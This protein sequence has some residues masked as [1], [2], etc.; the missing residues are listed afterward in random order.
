M[1]RIPVRQF[2]K[3]EQRALKKYIAFGNRVF[4]QAL[5]IQADNY[6]VFDEQPMIDAYKR[7]YEFAFIDAAKRNYNLVRVTNQKDFIPDGFF[8]STF[9]GFIG[10]YIENDVIMRKLIKNVNDNTRSQIAKAIG[11]GLEEGL[12]TGQLAESIIDFVVK[13][14]R[15]LGIART[16]ATRANA[17]GKKRSAQMWAVETGTKLYKQWYHSGNPNEPRADHL[18]INGEIVREDK[19]FSIGVM[20]PGDAE[21]PPEQTINCQC[22]VVFLSEDYVRRYHQE[23][24]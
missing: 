6:G 24:L 1:K 17:E 19:T 8:L 18:M 16:E 13:P 3:D 7:F 12:T 23:F 2:I 9:R 4:L 5:K 10:D 21:A 22:T 15:A 11:I 20:L 14:A